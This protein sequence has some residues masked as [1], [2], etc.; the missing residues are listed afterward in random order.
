MIP[1][2]G[3]GLL[4]TLVER[5]DLHPTGVYPVGQFG[6]PELSLP[7]SDFAALVEREALTVRLCSYYREPYGVHYAITE[8]GGARI[9][10]KIDGNEFALWQGKGAEVLRPEEEAKRCG[11]TP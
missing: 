11:W 1:R 2:A 9:L 3:L 10:A 8:M 4:Y 6:Q 7:P 5:H